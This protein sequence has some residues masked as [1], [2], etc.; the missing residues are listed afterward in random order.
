MNIGQRIADIR[1]ENNLTQEEF[2]DIFHVTR[3]T[4]SNWETEKNYPD[5]KILVD[6]SDHFQISLDQLLK[7][8]PDMI[9][10]IDRERFLGKLKRE[11]KIIDFLTGAGTGL[12]IGCL[13]SPD[14]WKKTLCIIIGIL[15]MIIGSYR[16]KAYD[17]KV[18]KKL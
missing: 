13:Y 14:S 1:K 4:V 17:Q 15:M 2:G 18:L 12:V 5:L 11:K 8:D 3:Q 10:R 7:E 16:R 9:E 6:I